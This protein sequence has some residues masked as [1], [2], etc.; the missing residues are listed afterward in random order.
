MFREGEADVAVLGMG[1]LDDLDG[2]VVMVEDT[3]RAQ[4]LPEL[5]V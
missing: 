2:R 3:S 4:R 1:I 5:Q